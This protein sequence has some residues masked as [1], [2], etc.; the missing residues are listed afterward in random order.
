MPEAR[1]FRPARRSPVGRPAPKDSLRKERSDAQELAHRATGTGTPARL[2][3]LPSLF[4]DPL[5]FLDSLRT[6]G[7]VVR[8][9]LGTLPVYF[10]TTADLV[11]E[12]MA[13]QAR[14]VTKGWLY[15]RLS[16]LAERS[17]P[18]LDGGEVHRRH[19]RLMQPL[20]T[21]ARVADYAQVMVRR[22]GGRASRWT[23][24]DL[25]LLDR[26]V[27]DLV[28]G[29]AVKT[30]FRSSIGQRVAAGLC[31]DTRIISKNALLRT[32]C[33]P[34]LERLP[35]IPA[36]R[37]FDAAAARMKAVVDEVVAAHRSDGADHSDLL[38]TLL[39]A[40]DADTGV[41]LSDA[42]VRDELVMMLLAGGE[43][44]SATTSWVFHEL[45][46]APRTQQRLGDELDTVL[47]TREMGHQELERM[48]F[49][50]WVVNEAQRLHSVPVL[51][52]HTVAPLDLNDRAG[53]SGPPSC[54][55]RPCLTFLCGEA[56][57]SVGPGGAPGTREEA[58]EAEE[59]WGR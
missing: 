25:I 10:V 23:A 58:K 51:T 4:R 49:T 24:G 52:R 6:Y 3:H 16:L 35:V 55:E 30:M 11:R 7:P 37:R 53:S 33:P 27:A 47:T 36:V 5:A 40:R 15:G 46:R 20:F 32:V 22:A 1:R 2:G 34:G 19:R 39:A 57:A 17:L 48:K 59:A 54:Q 13:G 12:V 41:R 38:S 45:G 42:E 26:E 44:C 14:S 21:P 50:T 8:V 9:E 28:M 18:V 29:T 56:P 31:R 43:T